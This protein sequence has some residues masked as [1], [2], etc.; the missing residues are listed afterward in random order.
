MRLLR[1]ENFQI[2]KEDPKEKCSDLPGRESWRK[3]DHWP[4]SK[5]HTRETRGQ[6][7]KC[8]LFSLGHQ[9]YMKKHIL[10]CFFQNVPVQDDDVGGS[11]T[12]LLLVRSRLQSEGTSSVMTRYQVYIYSI[13]EDQFGDVLKSQFCN[14]R[15]ASEELIHDSV[16]DELKSEAMRIKK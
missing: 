14:Q 15:H 1:K 13:V 10:K 7:N 6:G 3:T 11:W 4:G 8:N 2:C 5:R 9:V 12:H 16:I